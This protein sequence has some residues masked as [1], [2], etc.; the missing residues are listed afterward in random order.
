M[1]NA[2]IAWAS[3]ISDRLGFPVAGDWQ[4]GGPVVA[5]EFNLIF[6]RGGRQQ[7]DKD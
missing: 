3:L 7:K 1:K 5:I 6:T 2:I 4:E